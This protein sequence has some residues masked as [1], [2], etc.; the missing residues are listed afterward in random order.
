MVYIGKDAQFNIITTIII[1]HTRTIIRS[2][3]DQNNNIIITRTSVP[4]FDFSQRL[5][6]N[7][8][9]LG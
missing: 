4:L 2:L 9:F 7:P 3:K 5:V 8:Q 1:E 6:A